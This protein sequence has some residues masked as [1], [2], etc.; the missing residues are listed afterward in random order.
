MLEIGAYFLQRFA[1]PL[2]TENLLNK[3]GGE[4]FQLSHFEG[5]LP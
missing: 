5:E 3:I 2:C 4:Y 1:R